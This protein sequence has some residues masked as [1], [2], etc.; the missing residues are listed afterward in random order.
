MPTVPEPEQ[1][2]SVTVRVALP[3]PV[4][5]CAQVAPPVVSSVTFASASVTVEAPV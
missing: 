5:A 1:L 4:T 2:E 3:E